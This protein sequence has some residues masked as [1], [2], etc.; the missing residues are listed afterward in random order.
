[1]PTGELSL[2]T[3]DHKVDLPVFQHGHEVLAAVSQEHIPSMAEHLDGWS[4]QD[5]T[6]PEGVIA[7]AQVDRLKKSAHGFPA[8]ALE[9]SWANV[10]M[11]QLTMDLQGHK[12]HLEQEFETT[13]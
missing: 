2:D 12:T 6:T 4:Q 1:M 3:Y 8:D 5:T 7:Q 9:A 13:A 11:M 10:S